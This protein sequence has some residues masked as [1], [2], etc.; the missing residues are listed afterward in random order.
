[1]SEIAHKQLPSAT[2]MGRDIALND[3]FSASC[4]T[5]L[6]RMMSANPAEEFSNDNPEPIQEFSSATYYTIFTIFAQ[7]T[8]SAFEETLISSKDTDI[9]EFA[10]EIASVYATLAEGQKPLGREFE[11]VWDAN[12]EQLYE[13]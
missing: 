3:V 5:I 13:S 1:M 4:A 2:T 6:L 8:F 7:P 11:A 9:Q 12:I 10:Q